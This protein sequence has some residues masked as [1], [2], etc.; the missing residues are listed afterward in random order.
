MVV[1]YFTLWADGECLFV[2][3]FPYEKCIMEMDK[4]SKILETYFQ[5]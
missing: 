5:F 4:I 1:L 2:V 3:D